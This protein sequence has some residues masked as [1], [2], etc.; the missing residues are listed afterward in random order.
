MF[1]K[2]CSNAAWKRATRANTPR[3]GRPLPLA[4]ISTIASVGTSV[5]EKKYDAIIAKITA[6]ASGTNR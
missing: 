4:R 3:G 1:S 6:S 5:R 2:R